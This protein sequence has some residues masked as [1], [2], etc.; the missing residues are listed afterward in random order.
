[1]GEPAAV[2]D[3]E[4]VAAVPGQFLAGDDQ[5]PAGRGMAQLVGARVAFVAARLEAD[6][7]RVVSGEEAGV[8]VDRGDDARGAQPDQDPVVARRAA[9]PGLPAVDDLAAGPVVAGLERGRGR[10]EQVLLL[11]EGL[12]AGRDH[13]AAEP[14]GGEVGHRDHAGPPAAMTSVMDAL[15]LTFTTT[16]FTGSS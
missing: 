9:A 3:R 16:I 8:D 2:G 14:A 6:G 12:V 4:E 7:L 15:V 11:A 13:A 1:M 10:G 5:L